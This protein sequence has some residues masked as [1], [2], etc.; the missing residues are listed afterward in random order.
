VGFAV[1][2]AGYVVLRLGEAAGGA[3]L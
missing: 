1:V 2:L 3:F